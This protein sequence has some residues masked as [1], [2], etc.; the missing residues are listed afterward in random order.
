MFAVRVSPCLLQ[1]L[2]Q[3]NEKSE[4]LERCE[5]GSKLVY[6]VGIMHNAVS[7]PVRMSLHRPL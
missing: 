7:C 2:A 6:V 4:H 1:K 5:R 3:L